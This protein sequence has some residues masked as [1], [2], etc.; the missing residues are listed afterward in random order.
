MDAF[1]HITSSSLSDSTLGLH[2]EF[3][4][5]K[6]TITS[7]EPGY[8]AHQSGKVIAVLQ[9]DAFSTKPILNFQISVGDEVVDIQGIAAAG[10]SA[11]EFK[12]AVSGIQECCCFSCESE[13]ISIVVHRDQKFICS[14]AEMEPFLQSFFLWKIIMT[15]L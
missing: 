10:R 6:L 15:F 13:Y 3:D 8:P 4:M 5:G 9:Q 12:H 1:K 2:L 14:F 7:L 11:Q